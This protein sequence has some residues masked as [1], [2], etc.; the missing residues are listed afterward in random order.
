MNLL[1]GNERDIL[2]PMWHPNKRQWIVIW[3]FGLLFVFL[4][5]DAVYTLGG[6]WPILLN[7]D[8]LVITKFRRS[9]AVVILAAG[10]LLTWQLSA[11]T[12]R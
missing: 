9:W 12:K 4:M 8:A 2:T 1:V 11:K 10:L 5:T 7:I 3:I 6:L